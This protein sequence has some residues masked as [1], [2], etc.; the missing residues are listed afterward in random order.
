MLLESLH[1]L[2]EKLRD[3]IEAHGDALRKN[4]IQTRYALIDPLL[5]E[6]GWDIEDPAQVRPEYPL[7]TKYSPA[8]NSADYALLSGGKIAV[9]VEAKRLGTSLEESVRQTVNYCNLEGTEH[10]AV[11]DGRHWE[12]Y[13][14]HL[15]GPIEQKRIVDF[16]LRRTDTARICLDAL[17]L[18]RPSV[19]S[20]HVALAK[21][22]V[23]GIPHDHTSTTSSPVAV[24]AIPEQNQIVPDSHQWQ[25]LFSVTEKEGQKPVEMLFPDNSRAE[26][27]NWR[28]ALTEVVRWLVNRRMLHESN[29]PIKKS[30]ATRNMVNTE[31]IHSN[32][33][34][35]RTAREV[36]GLYVELNHSRRGL[37][38][39]TKTIIEHVGQDPAQFKVRFS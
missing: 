1:E 19:Q 31:P 33:V 2:V 22:P 29:C 15:P 16:D 3:R 9:I 6:L 17:A 13:G 30:R 10:F 12:I 11:T 27:R 20:G 7:E 5:R 18:W 14:T 24:E 38:D 21:A 32:G 4:E 35:F 34:P 26:M 28:S 25:E 36:G 8:T 23:V 39:S 37:L